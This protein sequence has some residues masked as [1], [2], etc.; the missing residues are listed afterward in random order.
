MGATVESQAQDVSAE[1]LEKASKKKKIAKSGSAKGPS[2]GTVSRK[3]PAAKKK[4]TKKAVTRKKATAKKKTASGKKP[5]SRTGAQTTPKKTSQKKRASRRVARSDSFARP[6]TSA[7]ATPSADTA[8]ADHALDDPNSI[9]WMVEQAEKA[10]IAVKAALA[11]QALMER[12][13]GKLPGSTEIRDAEASLAES[14]LD[15]GQ[16]G[17]QKKSHTPETPKQA[18]I[19]SS[20]KARKKTRNKKGRKSPASDTARLTAEPVV[21]A[22]GTNI[23]LFK[24]R[25]D[26]A[27]T[28]SPAAETSAPTPEP[29]LSRE[30]TAATTSPDPTTAQRVESDAQTTAQAQAV[31]AG[32]SKYRLARV[33]VAGLVLM[34]GFLTWRYWSPE[35]EAVATAGS[36][37]PSQPEVVPQITVSETVRP[38]ADE[39]PVQTPAAPALSPA[40]ATTDMAS[41]SVDAAKD[42][43]ADP[44]TVA[45]QLPSEQ[46]ARPAMRP[47]E[48]QTAPPDAAPE[49]VFK[50]AA[51]PSQRSRAPRYGYYPQAPAWQQQ[52]YRPAYPRAPA[53]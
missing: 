29:V 52:Y 31:A 7:T 8:G 42:E 45:A 20:G 36:S 12:A 10:L 19:S 34:V 6:N 51:P 46:P 33:L 14:A 53:R 25:E 17:Q 13:A 41:V 3:K 28:L 40:A 27:T 1:T 18:A 38:A 23:V 39:K 44:P 48:E 11:E 21:S 37:V 4:V 30:M 2:G 5:A 9:V 24:P 43:R 16:A 35:D 49:P 15:A 32:A 47:V 22:T 50:P 26:P